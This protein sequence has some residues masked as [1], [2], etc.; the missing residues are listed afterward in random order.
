MKKVVVCM[1]FAALAAMGAFAQIVDVDLADPG[2]SLSVGATFNKQLPVF[3]TPYVDVKTGKSV[4]VILGYKLVFFLPV[5]Y[6]DEKALPGFKRVLAT[7]T[8][9]VQIQTQDAK[10]KQTVSDIQP[11]SI[12]PF[13]D[14]K[15]G[16][17]YIRVIVIV[18]VNYLNVYFFAS[19]NFEPIAGEY[20]RETRTLVGQIGS[21]PNQFL[22]PSEAATKAVPAKAAA[23]TPDRQF[24]PAA[25]VINNGGDKKTSTSGTGGLK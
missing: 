7:D 20:D 8:L 6:Q 24:V 23:P 2:R 11:T 16:A 17:D 19:A 22:Q 13:K 9:K 1:L 18:P 10:K 21:D 5:S 12:S 25:S 4:S 3:D 15:S 14:A